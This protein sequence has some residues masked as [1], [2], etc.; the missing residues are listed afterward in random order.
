MLSAEQIFKKAATIDEILSDSFEVLPSQKTDTD[1][2][3]KRLAAWCRAS[4]NGNWKQ[5]SNRL[6]RDGLNY[7]FVLSRFA[8]VKINQEKTFPLWVNDSLWVQETFHQKS[9]HLSYDIT[10]SYY[11]LP[12]EQLFT[13]LV[14]EAEKKIIVENVHYDVF[15]QKTF[16]DSIRK[17]LYKNLID[18]AAP[19]LFEKFKNFK[20]INKNKKYKNN[21]IYIAFIEEHLVRN[22]MIKIFLEKPVFLRLISV[23]V[24]QWVDTNN[25]F[26]SRFLE[27]YDAIKKRFFPSFKNKFPKLNSIS[28]QISDPHNSGRSVQILEFNGHLKLVYKPKDCRLDDAF[29]K[30]VKKLNNFNPPTNLRLPKIFDREIYT[31]TEFI[32]HAA[33]TNLKQVEDYYYRAGA[34]LSLFHNFAGTDMHFENIIAHSD[35][36]VPIDIEMILQGSF[37]EFFS[38]DP[39]KKAINMATTKSIN[40]VMSVG[41]LP[42]YVRSPE[43][44]MIRDFG[45][46]SHRKDPVK[47]IV[48]HNLATDRLRYS[49]KKFPAPLS[50]NL[51]YIKNKTKNLDDFAAIFLKGYKEYSKFLLATYKKKNLIFFLEDFKNL[52]A[53]KVFRPTRFYA[54]LIK[55]LKNNSL[56]DD[57][58]TWSADL[59]FVARFSDWSISD[60]PIWPILEKERKGLVELNIPVFFMH[61]ETNKIYNHDGFI[62]NF[63]CIPGLAQAKTRLNSL[64]NREIEWQSEIIK[65]ST[66]SQVQFRKNISKNLKSKKIKTFNPDEAYKFFSAEVNSIADTIKELAI[67]ESGTAS[68]LCIDWVANSE[69]PQLSP[70]GPDLYSGASGIAL[71]F[72]AYYSVFKHSQ[73]KEIALEAITSVRSDL[74]DS[75]AQRYARSIGIGGGSGIGSIIYAFSCISQLLDDKSVLDD[76]EKIALLLTDDLIK[77]DFQYD[78]MGGSAGCILALL[79]LH[80]I[81]HNKDILTKAIM[82]GE[83]L[84]RSQRAAH[85]N[86]RSWVAQ[87]LGKIPFSG[88][89]HGASGFAYALGLLANVT[90]REDF[91]LASQESLDYDNSFYDESKFNWLPVISNEVQGSRRKFKEHICQWCYGAVGVGLSRIGLLKFSSHNKTN[92]EKDLKKSLESISKN[93]QY[94]AGDS[95]CCGRMGHVEFLN[96]VARFQNSKEIKE[97]AAQ[98]LSKVIQE[99]HLS[100]YQFGGVNDSELHLNLFRGIAGIGYTALRQIDSKL[101]N[102][103]IWE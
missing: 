50:T 59:D 15:N 26:I 3:A 10:R 101:P 74:T 71:F 14:N 72:A 82:C 16:L 85:G 36:P 47:K 13:K 56:M 55:R 30:L 22:E 90:Q 81:T 62:F 77:I 102:I 94:C 33:S 12:F 93:H 96:E 66:F 51:P 29:S 49:V 86:Y 91:A 27:D 89:A 65:V 2:A 54:T 98:K 40:S 35:H 5:F 97:E 44:G 39:S 1:I 9:E 7:E 24:R 34:W 46:L 28:G 95:M 88:L 31:W 76:A 43:D 18:F 53:R 17:Q 60:D 84:L 19:L 48:W 11:E 100:C 92:L 73:S 42:S 38:K 68:W 80:R 32:D 23:L 25:E 63:D 45:G 103:L 64:S 41:F 6:K 21:K 52:Y 69:V 57:G 87:G 70:I 83:H 67:R 61:V 75:N 37:A 8:T 99:S 4:S 20:K 79:K 78:L 58:I